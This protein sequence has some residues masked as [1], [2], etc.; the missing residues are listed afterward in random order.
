MIAIRN[1]CASDDV[2]RKIPKMTS[3]LPYQLG[4][5][6]AAP[7]R[8]GDRVEPHRYEHQEPDG[9]PDPAVE[10]EVPRWRPARHSVVGQP[11]CRRARRERPVPQHP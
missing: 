2:Y 10:Q 6:P 9:L 8:A 5:P 3:K 1:A 4:H 11:A 7:L